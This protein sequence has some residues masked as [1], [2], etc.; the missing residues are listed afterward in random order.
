VNDIRVVTYIVIE[1][2]EWQ[3]RSEDG[4]AMKRKPSIDYVIQATQRATRE[5]TIKRIGLD[6]KNKSKLKVVY[7]LFCVMSFQ[8]FFEKKTFCQ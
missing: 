2:T 3:L 7:M 5:S 6:K 4:Q 8:Q 1:S